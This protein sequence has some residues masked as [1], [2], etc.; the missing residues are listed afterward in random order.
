MS[1]LA[2]CRAGGGG[3]GPGAALSPLVHFRFRSYDGT[4][5]FVRVVGNV[6]VSAESDVT[7]FIEP[8]AAKYEVHVS[9]ASRAFCLMKGSQP[10]AKLLTLMVREPTVLHTSDGAKAESTNA[11]LAHLEC[12]VD[13]ELK[14]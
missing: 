1:L 8:S 9:S 3:A 13:L 7:S 10:N 11:A 14:R 2:A 5:Q 6:N 12:S 4:K